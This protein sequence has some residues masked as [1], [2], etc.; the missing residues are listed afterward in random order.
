[1]NWEVRLYIAIG[2]VFLVGIFYKLLC[3][4]GVLKILL[5]VE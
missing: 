4:E 2:L 3:V 5:G 1:M